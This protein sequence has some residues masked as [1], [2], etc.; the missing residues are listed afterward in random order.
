MRKCGQ[1]F[2]SELSPC[3]QSQHG[4]D[5]WPGQLAWNIYN[6][7]EGLLIYFKSSSECWCMNAFGL[8][9]TSREKNVFLRALSKLLYPL[10]CMYLSICICMFTCFI[11]SSSVFAWESS[12]SSFPW[13]SLLIW[14]RVKTWLGFRVKLWFW[15]R[16]N[17]CCFELFTTSHLYRKKQVGLGF[18]FLTPIL[19]LLLV[20]ISFVLPLHQAVPHL[21]TKAQGTDNQETLKFYWGPTFILFTVFFI[22]VLVF[23]HI[24][25]S[26]YRPASQEHLCYRPPQ[27]SPCEDRRQCWSACKRKKMKQRCQQ[28]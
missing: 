17:V 21:S 8:G 5:S 12:S 24:V 10:P 13:A 20:C 16:V 15:S 19:Q 4:G 22:I 14:L 27:S 3:N 23:Y 25:S 2:L 7:R 6:K 28:T 9:M 11:S 26:I 18:E 1:R